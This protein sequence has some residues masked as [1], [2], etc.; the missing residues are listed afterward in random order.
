MNY[1]TVKET[2]KEYIIT[3]IIGDLK[4]QIEQDVFTVPLRILLNPDPTE[5]KAFVQI[6]IF[7]KNLKTPITEELI[8]I[9]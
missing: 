9:F 7:G 3:E 4:H 6:K 5:K 1:P 8:L 2:E